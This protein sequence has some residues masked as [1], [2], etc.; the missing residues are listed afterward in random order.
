MEIVIASLSS[1]LSRP[2]RQQVGALPYRVGEDG[3][4]RILLITSRQSRSWIIPKGNL[5]PGRTWQE[6][7]AQEAYE[8]AGIVGRIKDEIG[9]YRYRKSR[10]FGP[11]PL[12]VVTVYPLEVERHE[13][14]W[15]EQEQR[16]QCWSTAGAAARMVR[17]R[18][19]ARLIASFSLGIDASRPL[20]SRLSRSLFIPDRKRRWTDQR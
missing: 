16:N 1:F 12:C 11:G 19:L 3:R 14:A 4:I 7:A 2:R 9:H 17:N 13:D 10:P 6:A 8:E 5:M 15:P 20:L 18:E